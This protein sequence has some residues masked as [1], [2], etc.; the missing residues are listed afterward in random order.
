MAD[1]EQFE[2]LPDFVPESLSRE[3]ITASLVK[4][5]FGGSTAPLFICTRCHE[6]IE[7]KMTVKGSVV[8]NIWLFICGVLPG[9]IYAVWR[10]TSRTKRCPKCGSEDFVPIETPRGRALYNSLKKSESSF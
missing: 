3:K 7:P 9:I 2:S 6:V 8:V 1:E 4:K 10:W 5:Q